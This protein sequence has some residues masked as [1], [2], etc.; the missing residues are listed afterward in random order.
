MQRLACEVRD[1]LRKELSLAPKAVLQF[2]ASISRCSHGYM[3]IN[4]PDNFT[5]VD[6]GRPVRVTV[7]VI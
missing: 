1:E 5:D 7:Q 2:D 3:V 6:S 4:L